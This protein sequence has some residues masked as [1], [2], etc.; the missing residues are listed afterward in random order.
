MNKKDKIILG[1]NISIMVLH[2][3]YTIANFIIIGTLECQNTQ[4]E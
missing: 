1:V 2:L 4:I 3:C